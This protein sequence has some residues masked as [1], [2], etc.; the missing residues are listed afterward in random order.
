MGGGR[1]GEVLI[2][3]NYSLCPS[4]PELPVSEPEEGSVTLP[5]IEKN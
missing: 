5:V 3:I 2:V 4:A 1:G